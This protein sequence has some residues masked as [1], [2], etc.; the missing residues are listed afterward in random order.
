MVPASERA[1]VALDVVSSRE[2]RRYSETSAASA[3]IALARG[4][5]A[6]IGE[7]G[8]RV[9]LDA[10]QVRR[11]QGARARHALLVAHRPLAAPAHLA[12]DV[13]GDE[14]MRGRWSVIGDTLRIT[15]GRRDVVRQRRV[16]AVV[17]EVRRAGTQRG[18]GGEV[19]SRR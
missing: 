17:D 3:P 15:R 2:L 4:A 7:V 14:P 5:I 19:R 10:V 1:R 8:S 12:E 6:G 9:V 13:V 16:Q 18:Q 11:G